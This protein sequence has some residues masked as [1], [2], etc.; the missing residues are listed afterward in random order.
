[1]TVDRSDRERAKGIPADGCSVAT[2]QHATELPPEWDALAGSNVL[3]KRGPLA[4]IESVRKCDQSYYLLSGVRPDSI[5]VTYRHQLDI[6][7]YGIG[8]LA[9][10]VTIIGMPCS[11]SSPGC[12]I[13]NETRSAAA[14]VIGAIPGARLLLNAPASLHLRGLSRGQT[15]PACMLTIAWGSFDEYL[16]AMRSHYRYRIR[17]AQR[18]WQSVTLVELDRPQ[19]FDDVLYDLYLNVYQR[20]RYKIEQLP[21]GFFQSFPAR[22]TKFVVNGKPIAFVQTLQAGDRLHFLFGGLDYGVSRLFDTYLNILLHVVRKGI[23]GGCHVVDL[24]QTA[25]ATKMRLGCTLAPRYFLA[26]H[27]NRLLSAVIARF[28]GPLGYNLPLECSHVFR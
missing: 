24:G 4:A 20:S 6:L 5:I 13:G 18:K 19:D 27:A 22:I 14:D 9:L 3:L 16:E 8:R 7:T 15:L 21:I 23:E 28:A 11:V 26:G 2:Y 12:H 17:A 10:P 25:E 1:M